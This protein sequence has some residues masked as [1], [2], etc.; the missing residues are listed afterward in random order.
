MDIQV[1]KVIEFEKVILLC[2]CSDKDELQ[3]Q[4]FLFLFLKKFVLI[5]GGV[6]VNGGGLVDVVVGQINLVFSQIQGVQFIVGYL[7]L[8]V[9]QLQSYEVNVVK[10]LGQNKNI[11][12]KMLFGVFNII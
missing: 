10:M 9:F 11:V 5:N 12:F 8:E 6:G 3:C 7:S 1:F 2:I 4:F